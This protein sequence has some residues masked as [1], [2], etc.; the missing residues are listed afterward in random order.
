MTGKEKVIIKKY[1][2][3]RLYDTRQKRYITLDELT[4]L[5]ESGLEVQVLDSKTKEDLTNATLIQVILETHKSSSTQL[6]SSEFLHQLIQ[7][8]HARMNEFFD[9][10]MPQVFQSYM[11]WQQTAQNQ[12]FEWAS[13]AKQLGQQ[14]LPFGTPLSSMSR[15]P[16]IWPFMNF[17]GSAEQSA[18]SEDTSPEATQAQIEA[19]KQQLETLQARL[20]KKK[21]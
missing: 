9:D 17:P 18:T 12:F 6:F 21:P 4:E 19:L 16:M 10:I 13:M 14:M 11:T 7:Y 20:K 3:R 5:I 8:R 2:N 15:V 1:G